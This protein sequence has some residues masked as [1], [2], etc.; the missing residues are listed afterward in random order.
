MNSKC[1]SFCDVFINCM[2]HFSCLFLY[3][4]WLADDR[5]P[6][7][8]YA[9]LLPTHC[10]NVTD[11]T[12]FTNWTSTKMVDY[13]LL[14]SVL[15]RPCY[16]IF[17][18]CQRFSCLMA[19]FYLNMM[20]NA[21]WFNVKSL[22]DIEYKLN[23]GPFSV[24]Y[25][26]LYVGTISVAMTFPFLGALNIMF[27]YRKTKVNTVR[28]E[29]VRSSACLPHWIHYVGHI[30][31]VLTIVCG[32]LVTF[33]YSL[34]WGGETSNNW[35]MSIFFGSLLDTVIGPVQVCSMEYNAIECIPKCSI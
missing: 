22:N 33:L 18:R 3:H 14:P 15:C 26:Q 12:L 24:S 13:M 10:I 19:T 27:R 8:R 28:F 29:N 31:C 25:M 34:Q 6:C 17:T 21:M 32:F 23:I 5:G 30:V 16:S 9:T 20:V 1:S 2:V 35:L 4:N 7:R 11:S